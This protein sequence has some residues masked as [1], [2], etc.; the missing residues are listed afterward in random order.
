LDKS[1]SV[2]AQFLGAEDQIAIRV[3][4]G[5]EVTDQTLRISAN[6]FITL[7]L[8]GQVHAAGITVEQLESDIAERLKKYFNKPEVSV[9]LVETRSQP[10]SIIG[11]VVSPGV[12]QLQGRKTL[13]EMLSLAGG[14]TQDAAT[15]K[16]TRRPEWGRI[17]LPTVS[18]DSKGQSSTAEISVKDLIQGTD[19]GLNIVIFPDD[20]ISVLKAEMLKLYVVGDVARP[21]SIIVGGHEQVTVLQAISMAG[22]VSKTANAKDAR[23]LRPNP[24]SL[25]RD[26]I[27]VD[28][29]AL[30]A[31]KTADITMQPEDILVVPDKKATAGGTLETALRIAA[32]VAI[33]GVRP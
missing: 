16:I 2:S 32:T 6:G 10:V 23:I 30:L 15:I 20:I 28:L 18:D 8:I 19:P 11:A 13:L 25:K 26:E 4:N 17:G 9:T 27:P 14:T 1:E 12:R 7:P 31:G 29:K 5:E 3:S 24:A 22:G 21:G 33:I